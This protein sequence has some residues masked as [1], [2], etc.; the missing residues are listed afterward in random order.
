VE[1]PV[2]AQPNKIKEGEDSD[3]DF[4][5]AFEQDVKV[6]KAKTINSIKDIDFIKADFTRFFQLL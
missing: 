2:I 4:L 5:N 6:F 1:K 3:D